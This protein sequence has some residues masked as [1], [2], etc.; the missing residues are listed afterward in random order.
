MKTSLISLFLTRPGFQ[1]CAKALRRRKP[2][3]HPR[4]MVVLQGG[5]GSPGPVDQLNFSGID[6]EGLVLPKHQ[7]FFSFPPIFRRF[8]WRFPNFL[9][10]PKLQRRHFCLWNLLPCRGNSRRARGGRRIGG[11]VLVKILGPRG[12]TQHPTT[13]RL[14]NHGKSW[15][16]VFLS[17]WR[18]LYSKL[19]VR[20]NML[21]FG[22]ALLL[23]AG[24]QENIQH[25]RQRLRV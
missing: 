5:L 6:G 11:W 12:K 22:R 3:R 18:L 19:F 24:V 16:M 13:K 23:S 21:S 1:R 8:L 10:A 2:H 20:S 7:R 9:L 14:V 4:R 25:S 17:F 15:Q